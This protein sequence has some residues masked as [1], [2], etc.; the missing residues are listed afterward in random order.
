MGPCAAVCP[1]AD[2]AWVYNYF[3][4]AAWPRAQ[5]RSML[6]P[7]PGKESLATASG[8]A[9]DWPRDRAMFWSGDLS[10]AAWVNGHDHL[11]LVVADDG[12]DVAGAF[13]RFCDLIASRHSPPAFRL[14]PS[15]TNKT[16]AAPHSLPAGA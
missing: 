11:A 15:Y 7:N 10:T 3:Y 5:R 1:R 8:I 16:P 14:N 13:R 4:D 6:I 2:G 12:H 9:R